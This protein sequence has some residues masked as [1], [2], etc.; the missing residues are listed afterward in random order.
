MASYKRSRLN[1]WSDTGCPLEV[2]L[3]FKVEFLL[4]DLQQAFVSAFDPAIKVRSHLVQ[5]DLGFRQRE[6]VVAFRHEAG[7]A[8][9]LRT[10]G[11]VRGVEVLARRADPD[12][13]TAAIHLLEERALVTPPCHRYTGASLPGLPD[14]AGL[15]SVDPEPQLAAHRPAADRISPQALPDGTDGDAFLPAHGTGNVGAQ[16]AQR[17]VD[18]TTLS[19]CRCLG[20]Q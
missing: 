10:A 20:H 5:R 12:F 15:D 19:R 2:L 13:G 9:A 11:I 14:P 7:A 3:Q 17:L 18:C 1:G 6:A 16:P 8:P 4:E